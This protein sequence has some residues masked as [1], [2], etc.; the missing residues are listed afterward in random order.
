MPSPGRPGVNQFETKQAF[1]KFIAEGMESDAAALACGVSQPLGPRWFRE[2]GGMPPI[3]LMPRSGLYLSFSEREK[4]A[5]LWAQGYGI[6]EI[7]RRLGRSPST[8]SRELRRN[9]ATRGGT[10]IYRATVAQ[11]KA[12]RVAERPKAVK[13]AGSERLRT[14]VQSRLAG[15]VADCGLTF[16]MMSL[17]GSYTKPSIRRFTYKAAA[18]CDVNCPHVCARAWHCACRAL[19][20]DNGAKVLSPPRS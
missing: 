2:V 18:R 10:L 4:I 14:Y 13:L 12:E 17:C 11:W 16:L 20:R 15:A 8:I 1:W 5:L 3:E 19:E 9:A 7:A 6:R